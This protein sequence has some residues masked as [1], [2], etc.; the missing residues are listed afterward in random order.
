ML[1]HLN[2]KYSGDSIGFEALV[3]FLLSN[4]CSFGK[5]IIIFGAVHIVNKTKDVSILGKGE[6]ND[7]DDTTLTVEKEILLLNNRGNFV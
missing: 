3:S 2:T 5:I 1:I 6:S 4:G 7:L